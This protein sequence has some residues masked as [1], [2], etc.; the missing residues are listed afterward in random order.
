MASESSSWLKYRKV[1]IRSASEDTIWNLRLAFLEVARLRAALVFRKPSDA[2]GL[3]TGDATGDATGIP[4]SGIVPKYPDEAPKGDASGAPGAPNG[5][6]S[7]GPN[8]DAS[9]APYG[10]ASGGPNGDASGLALSPLSP[11]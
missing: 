10:D 1:L 8:G 4:D 7:G 5:D 2:V 3:P 11:K 9:G 6:A